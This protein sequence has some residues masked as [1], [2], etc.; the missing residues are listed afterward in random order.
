MGCR[1]PGLFRLS[2]HRLVCRAVLAL[3]SGRTERRPDFDI[4]DG[5]E[6]D[7]GRG[8]SGMKFVGF[9]VAAAACCLPTAAMACFLPEGSIEL[10]VATAADEQAAFVQ[11][12]RY[13]SF[14]IDGEMLVIGGYEYFPFGLPRAI[15]PRLL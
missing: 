13:Q 7:A 3:L 12:S 6:Q 5:R 10:Q 9:A 8:R 1:T 14:A 2:S 11:S 4:R 15:N